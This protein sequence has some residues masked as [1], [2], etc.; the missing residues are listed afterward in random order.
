MSI[1]VYNLG[2]GESGKSTIL[3]QFRILHANGFSEAEID[4]FKHQIRINILHAI[5]ALCRASNMNE[6]V[7]PARRVR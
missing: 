7:T 3:K 5:I 4:N 6:F 2:T 1:K